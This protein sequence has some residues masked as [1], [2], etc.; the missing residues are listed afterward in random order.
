[1]VYLLKHIDGIASHI[2]GHTSQREA[3]EG[4]ITDA[5]VY[6]FLLYGMV[7]EDDEQLDDSNTIT[8]DE[9]YYER[10]TTN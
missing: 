9:K 1:M 2:D 8:M 7:I 10:T 4:R 3:V 6:L 5:I